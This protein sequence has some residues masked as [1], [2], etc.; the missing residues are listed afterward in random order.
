[1]SSF[2]PLIRSPK[3]KTLMLRMNLITF[4]KK[5]IHRNLLQ[6]SN[7]T[8]VDLHRLNCLKVRKI[9]QN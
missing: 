9:N 2:R 4:L 8:N 6:V 1:M 3:T 5:P 7:Q